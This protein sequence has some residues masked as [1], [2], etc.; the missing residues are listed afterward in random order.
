M[1]TRLRRLLNIFR[2]G[3]V[4]DDHG[5]AAPE[6]TLVWF[7]HFHKAGG[8][9]IIEAARSAGYTFF[10]PNING[11]PMQSAKTPIPMWDWDKTELS[12]WLANQN[13]Q[14]V[15]FICAEFG[16]SHAVFD[17][18]TPSLKR[19]GSIRRPKERLI[20]N[21]IYDV[22][23]GYTK[24]TTI[25]DY[26]QPDK[27]HTM[28]DYYTRLITRDTGDRARKQALEAIKR[29]DYVSVLEVPETFSILQSHLPGLVSRHS[30]RTNYDDDAV[31]EAWQT[32]QSSNEQLD[33][34]CMDETKLYEAVRAHFVLRK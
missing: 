23:E 34:L 25:F 10:E 7:Q 19:V 33:A 12:E 31:R 24:A 28:P 1:H 2:T 16:F 6:H 26:M 5:L 4:S 17:I 8:T 27:T 22:A 30:N 11:N 20:S 32:V 15:N 18:T 14:G 13:E 3:T 29:F 21:F 9:S